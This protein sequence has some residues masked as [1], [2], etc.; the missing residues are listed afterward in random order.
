MTLALTSDS[1][2]VLVTGAASGMGLATGR[3]FLKAGCR[4]VAWDVDS[5]PLTDAWSDTVPSQV[6]TDVVDVGDPAATDAGA[7]RLLAAFDRLDVVVNNAA[8]HGAEWQVDCLT[9]S[10]GRWRKILDVNLLGPINVL[11]SCADA[12]AA[13]KGVV[14]NVSSMVAY[15]H[16]RSSPYSVT[17]T[18]VN[19]L[20]TSLAEELGRRGVRVVGVAPGFVATD[21]VVESV[22]PERIGTLI[23]MQCLPTVGQPDD[24]AEVTFFLASEQAR[25]ITGQTVVADLGIT[26]RP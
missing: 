24:I 23:A 8:L 22:G 19:G 7:T 4:V 21:T 10:P 18:A 2:V 1:R 12:L 9:L 13:A 14:V 15:G 3:R 25:M 17:K 16:G 20:T 11:R 6:L 5:A 26:R